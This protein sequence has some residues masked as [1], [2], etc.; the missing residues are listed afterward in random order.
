MSATDG[1][2]KQSLAEIYDLFRYALR[3]LRSIIAALASI[4]RRLTK[5]ENQ[6]K[7]CAERRTMWTLGLKELIL[8][9]AAAII[10]GVVMWLITR[11]G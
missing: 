3:K 5:L 10:S 1:K 2:P 4:D 6:C 9:V 7:D 8:G 11:G